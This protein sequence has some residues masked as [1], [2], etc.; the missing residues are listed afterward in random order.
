MANLVV[1]G[2]QWGDEGKGKVTDLLGGRAG[3]VVRFGGGANAG[4]TLVVEG[5]KT[6]LHLVPSGILHP[7]C[8]CVMGAG[9]AV[10]PETLIEEIEHC[11]QTGLLMDPGRLVV[12]KRAHT[13]FTYHKA[14]DAVRE[15]GAGAIG[16]TL[17]GI[18]PCYEDRSARRGL[19]LG[20]L[21]RPERLKAG[22]KANLDRIN[23]VLETSGQAPFVL[24]DVYDE[25]AEYGR[26]LKPFLGDASA[27]V[28][29]QI[30]EGRRVLFEGAQGALLDLGH[31]T[32]PYVTSSCTLASG[33][34]SGTGIGPTLI[35]QV[36][37]VTKAYTTRV[38]AGPFPTEDHGEVGETLRKQGGEYGA[39]TGRPRRCGWLDIGVL[40]KTIRLNG[41]TQLALTKLDVLKGLSGV[42]ISVGYRVNGR[43]IE[44]IPSDPEEL[45]SAEAVYEEME[46]FTEDIT[47]ARRLDDL[48]DAALA[49]IRRIE[50]LT[51]VP[52][53]LVSIGPGR[54]ETILRVDPYEGPGRP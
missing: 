20:T 14:L 40:R 51:G 25:Y 26:R 9:M 44:E 47:K 37:G 18:G 22:I 39:T 16:T 1:V 12:S 49:Y 17:R 35:D 54:S 6:V 4:H 30:R 7:E 27:F 29:G 33:A 32:Y 10:C 13:V 45:E 31:G 41:A 5:K 52:V 38:G 8:K 23:P 36:M 21:V 50:A 2:L 24:Q 19:H 15:Q 46:G 34:A 11:E 3:V 42:K 28:A 43:D 48:P 53:T